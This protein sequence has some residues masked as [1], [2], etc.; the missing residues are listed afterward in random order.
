[1]RPERLLFDRGRNTTIPDG[2]WVYTGSDFLPDGRFIADLDGVLI[3]FVHDP[4]TVIEYVASAGIGSYGS[5]V[6]DPNLGLTPGTPIK[7]TI[8]AIP[9]ATKP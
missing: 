7:L 9:G 8:R 1:M 3:G 4:S 5:I 2:T 6:I